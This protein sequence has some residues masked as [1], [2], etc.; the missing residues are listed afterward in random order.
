MGEEDSRAAL[1]DD[2]PAAS[3]RLIALII[4]SGLF[5]ENLDATVL[6]TAIPTMAHD[7]HVR[8]PQMSV[9][10]T[11]YLLALALFIPASGHAADR[12]GAKN[13]FRAAIGVFTAGSLVCAMSP[14]LPVM[15]ASRFAQGIGGAMMV[16]VGRLVLLRTVS[17]RD[18][19]AAYSWML[20]PG[21][22]GQISGP[23][24]GG[25]IV[26]YLHWRWIFR[27]N[28]PIGIAGIVLV[29][30]FIPDFRETTL[31]PF[32]LPGFILAGIALSAALFGFET[33][34]HG[35]PLRI[36]GP[37]LATAFLSG[38]LY[39]W[40]ARR[41]PHPVLDLSLLAIPTFRLSIIGGSLTR[42]TQGA[43]PF[44]LPLMMQLA[45]GLNAAKSGLITLGT[46]LGTVAMKGFVVPILRRWG[47]RASLT[48]IGV[49]AAC[50]YAVCG[51]F[52]PGW[53]F[54]LIFAVLIV[55]GFLMSFQF[56][57]YNTIAFDE[58]APE[59][60]SSANAFYSTLQQLMLSFGICTA[61]AALHVSTE[62]TGRSVPGFVDFS[63]AFWVV[64]AVSVCSFFANS[65]FD[66]Q[67]GRQMSGAA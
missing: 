16:P 50:S 53:P 42:I 46:A 14:T 18:L 38:L 28:L 43:Q 64:T 62:L 23:P 55:S 52:R 15:V 11:A 63:A 26:T 29:G 32:D 30:R 9:A 61:A 41:V 21:L 4:A 24:I 17:K 39:V 19:L 58:I 40:Y 37:L 20:M 44:L 65:R 3:Y 27:I 67:A 35:A 57:A 56:T 59:H 7:F 5:M 25:F 47:F 8:A 54:P 13:V 31:R 22:A 12:W 45:F 33:W 66:R 6:T 10:L 51:L 34:G 60:M 1:A 36:A 48:L 49:L 2:T